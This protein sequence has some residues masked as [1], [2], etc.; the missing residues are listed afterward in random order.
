[1]IQENKICQTFIIN[2]FIIFIILI[3]LYKLNIV[4]L[5]RAAFNIIL[6]LFHFS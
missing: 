3:L 1:M 4:Q 2:T 6:L 5:F